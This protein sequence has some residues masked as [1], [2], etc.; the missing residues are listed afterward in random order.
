MQFRQITEA[1]AAEDAE[2]DLFEF[3]LKRMIMRRLSPLFYH[4]RPPAIRYRRMDAVLPALRNLLS[5]LA[6][7]GTDS[8]ND[9]EQAYANGMR[10]VAGGDLPAMVALE[11]AGLAVVQAALEDL[12]HAV[13]PL[14]KQV[15]D[16][17]AACV[18]YDGRVTV[19][20]A[21]LLRAV[22]DTLAC[23]I[24]PFLPGRDVEG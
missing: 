21:E 17:C 4:V 8:R 9:A 2:I 20:E 5:C 1:L 23:P 13:P 10:R 6:Y 18:G 7:W 3:T 15:I 24:P 19:D 16:A 14:K 12:R 22:G 11:E